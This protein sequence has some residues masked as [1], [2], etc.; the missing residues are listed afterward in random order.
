VLLLLQQAAVSH[1]AGLVPRAATVL[2]EL[3]T[4]RMVVA[5]AVSRSE[6]ALRRGGG[7]VAALARLLRSQRLDRS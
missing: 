3:S 1:P 7:A 2:L 4:A 6:A 5:T